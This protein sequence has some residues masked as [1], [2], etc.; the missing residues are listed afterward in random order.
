[1]NDKSVENNK[2]NQEA[3]QSGILPQNIV[4]GT[5]YLAELTI[6]TTCVVVALQI[7]DAALAVKKGTLSGSGFW[8]IV[9]FLYRGWVKATNV[10]LFKV[11]SK[12]THTKTAEKV[13]GQSEGSSS[14]DIKDKPQTPF[15]SRSSS[16]L[17]GAGVET[18]G[19]NILKNLHQIETLNLGSN[20]SH[21]SWRQ[22]HNLYKLQT[23]CINGRFLV[24]IF[25]IIALCEGEQVVSKFVFSKNSMLNHLVSGGVCGFA[26]H[27]ISYPAS[28]YGNFRISQVSVGENGRLEFPS[29]VKCMEILWSDFK[30]KGVKQMVA[31]INKA[32]PFTLGGVRS[33]IV[34]GIFGALHSEFKK[35]PPGP[36]LIN[37]ISRSNFF[38]MK[39]PITSDSPSDPGFDISDWSLNGRS[40]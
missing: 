13:I 14:E 16:I 5:N 3:M 12:D 36:K 35:S 20:Y 18:V 31:K 4:T 1:M 26:A 7:L 11:T 27:A 8:G 6:T 22:F 19:L 9:D 28:E 32:S 24:S 37:M 15:N 29:T 39:E 34:F 21:S 17:V 23:V 25:N 10:T 40:K 33:G 30:Q 2:D 38:Q